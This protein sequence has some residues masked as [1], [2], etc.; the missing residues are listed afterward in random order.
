MAGVLALF[1]SPTATAALLVDIGD[2]VGYVGTNTPAHQDG[3]LSAAED[4]YF[5][6][7]V[8]ASSFVTTTAFS[9]T[10]TLR[11]A[12]NSNNTG[13][14]VSNGSAPKRAQSSGAGVFATEL[15]GDAATSWDIA[16]NGTER[17]PLGLEVAG[18]P[19]GQ[20]T[21][22]IVAPFGNYNYEQRTFAGVD[23]AN[24]S[25][26]STSDFTYQDT[27]DITTTAMWVEGDNYTAVNFT[28]T[29]GNSFYILV[30]DNSDNGISDYN[31]TLSSL[32]IV[33]VPEPATFAFVLGG[34]GLFLISRRRR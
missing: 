7:D 21:A 15:T 14:D 11:A 6:F 18:L 24:R 19:D 1:A 27:L 17:S 4:T 13:D 2:A 28:I 8:N 29:S 32:E 16:N 5:A 25:T 34:M 30:S 10:I 26:Y 31:T 12:R 22:Y 9:S 23:T 20:Y 3:G 33:A